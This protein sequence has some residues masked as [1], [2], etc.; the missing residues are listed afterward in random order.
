MVAGVVLSEGILL[1]IVLGVGA[2]S[3]ISNAFTMLKREREELQKT[4]EECRSEK[5]ESEKR[6]EE[7]R[8]Q[9]HQRSSY[10]FYARRSQKR[11]KILTN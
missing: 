4:L 7:T 2:A 6:L 1:P 3:Q 11:K 8:C 5:Y 9:F 10:N